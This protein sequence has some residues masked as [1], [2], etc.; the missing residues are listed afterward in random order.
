MLGICSNRAG[1]AKAVELHPLGLA[2]SIN[3][4]FQDQ[5]VQLFFHRKQRADGG[6]ED[7]VAQ[8][9]DGITVIYCKLGIDTTHAQLLGQLQLERQEAIKADSAT[10]ANH[11]GFADL[12]VRSEVDDAHAD[13]IFGIGQHEISYLGFRLAQLRAIIRNAAYQIRRI[14]PAPVTL[15]S[16]C[17][18][19]WAS[20]ADAGEHRSMLLFLLQACTQNY[21][22]CFSDEPNPAS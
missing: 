15:V 4:L 22:P 1:S 7:L 3:G 19:P 8:V 14:H 17:R 9:G 12:S 6:I 13:Y 20:T 5:G 16:E 11:G 21:E 2:D 18:T 10:E